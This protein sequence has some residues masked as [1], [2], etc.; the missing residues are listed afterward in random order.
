MKHPLKRRRAV[1]IVVCGNVCEVR[2]F[3]FVCKAQQMYRRQK[4]GSHL[5]FTVDH[6]ILQQA[7]A[8]EKDRKYFFHLKERLL[9]DHELIK[10]K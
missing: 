10:G 4:H 2:K 9:A 3:N 5:L 6:Q 7:E 8:C 1:R